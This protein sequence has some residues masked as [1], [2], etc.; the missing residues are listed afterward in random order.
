MSRVVVLGSLNAD[1]HL[2]VERHPAPGET[3]LAGT[4]AHRSGGKGANQA[5]A[6]AR[7]G[8]EVALLG[9]VGDDERGRAHLRHL[10]AS[11]VGTSAVR[12]LAGVP[13]GTAVVCTD[14]GGENTIVVAPG[15]NHRVGPGDLAALDELG[16]GDVLL[17]QLE[18]P[19][20]VVADG[21]RRAARR[22]ARVVL[23]LAPYAPLPDDVLAVADPVVVNEHEGALLRGAGLAPPSLLTTLGARGARWGDLEVPAERVRVVDT[24]GA[25]DAFCGALAAHLAAGADRAA[26]L[27]AATAAAAACVQH[28]GAQPP[29]SS[30]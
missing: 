10:R 17:A 18:L 25:G 30:G 28:E 29:A 15:A 8:A 13:T 20:D 6:A 19:L 3:V 1:L 14:A 12:V 16:P 11:G 24:T 27:A 4:V 26:A 2:G 7:A 21:V 5:L 22:G 23:N 9:A